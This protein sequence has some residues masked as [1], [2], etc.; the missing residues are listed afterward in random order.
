MCPSAAK[1]V[2]QEV[3]AILK[4]WFLDTALQKAFRVVIRVIIFGYLAEFRV[5]VPV[6]ALGISNLFVLPTVGKRCIY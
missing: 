6:K 3:R 4:R 2:A 5:C 1:S